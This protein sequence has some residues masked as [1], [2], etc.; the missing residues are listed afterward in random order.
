MGLWLSPSRNLETD[1]TPYLVIPTWKMWNKISEL[2]HVMFQSTQIF[3]FKRQ[4]SG[5][6]PEQNVLDPYSTISFGA[7]SS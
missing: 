4:K 7:D 2:L 5:Q 3:F 6:K 1:Q